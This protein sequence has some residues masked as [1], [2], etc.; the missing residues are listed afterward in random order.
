MIMLQNFK[1]KCH[2]SKAMAT[3]ENITFSLLFYR[4]NGMHW[5]LILEECTHLM[6][7]KWKANQEAH[8]ILYFTSTFIPRME[9]REAFFGKHVWEAICLSFVKDFFGGGDSTVSNTKNQPIWLRGRSWTRDLALDSFDSGNPCSICCSICSSHCF[10]Y[11]V[12]NVRYLICFTGCMSGLL[13]T[14]NS[15]I[16]KGHN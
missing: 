14:T 7:M 2:Q 3:W 1:L 13:N 6:K 12:I 8:L 5:T 16:S 9:Y 4:W 10:I 15:H 11:S